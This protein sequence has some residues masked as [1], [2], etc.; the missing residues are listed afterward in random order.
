MQALRGVMV[1]AID[2]VFL[3]S[4]GLVGLAFVLTLAL[5]ERPLQGRT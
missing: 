5:P 1:G 4:A 3:V 2:Q